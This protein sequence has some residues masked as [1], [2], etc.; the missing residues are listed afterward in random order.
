MRHVQIN[1]TKAAYDRLRLM[2]DP[3]AQVIPFDVAQI[4][5]FGVRFV[6][7]EHKK[8]QFRLTYKG[9]DLGTLGDHDGSRF[10]VIVAVPPSD[11]VDAAIRHV[12]QVMESHLDRVGS[13][14]S[15]E[16]KARRGS[17]AYKQMMERK[18]R[19]EAEERQREIEK[20]AARQKYYDDQ[21]KIA[22]M[23]LERDDPN[24]HSP[25]VISDL[26]REDIDL[27][28]KFKV[29]LQILTLDESDYDKRNGSFSL[30]TDKGSHW[31]FSKDRRTVTE[32][33]GSDYEMSRGNNILIPDQHKI[34]KI[35]MGIRERNLRI[36]DTDRVLRVLANVASSDMSIERYAMHDQNIYPH[37]HRFHVA[38]LGEDIH[39]KGE[40][41]R[42]KMFIEGAEV[43]TWTISKG[44][45]DIR[46][47]VKL[48]K[49]SIDL[50]GV[51]TQPEI[52]GKIGS[53]WVNAFVN[54][55]DAD[56]DMYRRFSVDEIEE[57]ISTMDFG[58]TL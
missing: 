8:N 19:A 12:F 5:P 13:I 22:M 56:P 6:D 48:S 25:T 27:I 20:E 21:R 40:L 3:L 32:R 57:D 28:S 39:L 15:A 9:A 46:E 45:G 7:T 36:G 29:D 30:R 51:L 53:L 24:D 16:S 42:V 47:T 31:F 58:Y 52:L 1:S 18:A 23:G 11:R 14:M 55:S 35:L 10:S 44:M 17:E 2:R 49:T 26:S 41:N 43:V 4:A 37:A 54:N 33:G 34:R 50:D 38:D